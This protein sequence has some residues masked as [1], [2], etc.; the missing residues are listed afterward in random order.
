MSTALRDAAQACNV[1]SAPETGGGLREAAGDAAVALRMLRQSV[2]L[3]TGHAWLSA[4]FVS[5]NCPQSRAC[6]QLRESAY[7]EPQCLPQFCPPTP[8]SRRACLA[9]APGPARPAG[10]MT[11]PAACP[12]A[13]AHLF[14]S[15]LCRRRVRQHDAADWIPLQ[16]ACHF[17]EPQCLDPHLFAPSPPHQCPRRCPPPPQG[18][19]APAQDGQPGR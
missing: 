17:T 6:K 9:R 11:A 5:I 8:A 18:T 10:D 13:C 7:P 1:M 12:G 14:P 4:P 3:F 19:Q 15:L 16:Q 2:L